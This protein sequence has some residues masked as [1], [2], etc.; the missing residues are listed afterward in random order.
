[1]LLL[2]PHAGYVYSGKVAAS[3]I[4]QIY[5]KRKFEHI[6][7]IGSSHTHLFHGVSIYTEGDYTTPLGNI[8]IDPLASKLLE[9]HS[10]F[11]NRSEIQAHEHALEVILPFLQ[12]WLKN[13]FSI[14]P[15]IIGGES[16]ETPH[17]LADI[18]KP[19]FNENN[20]FIISSDFSHYP[21]YNDALVADNAMAEAIMS[22][23]PERFMQ[24]KK[25]L[26]SRHIP[27]LATT[28][29]G[30]TAILTLLYLT[31]GNP[32]YRIARICYQNS[33]DS[34]YGQKNK[35][36]GYLAIAVYYNTSE[37]NPT[38]SY[39]KNEII[40]EPNDKQNLLTIAQNTLE[41]YVKEHTKYQ[42]PHSLIT[43][44]LQQKAG[45]FVTLRKDSKLRGCI[46]TFQPRYSLYLTIRNLTI[47]SAAYD[48]RFDPVEE[49]EL[50]LIDI[51]ISV[52]T[53]LKK[54][55][56]IDEIEIGKDGIF[57]K[58]GIFSGTF[59][60]QVATQ[61]HW[62]KEEFLGHC[63]R[64]KAGIG[65]NGWKDAEIFTFRTIVIE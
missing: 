28:A 50:P 47:S 15:I 34:P 29:C 56:N 51:E 62:T 18:L 54:I 61:M 25:E 45:A 38:I 24:T 32:Q 63:A 41:Q 19:Y 4:A 39:E 3:A 64:D 1:M 60:P 10:I 6:F 65:W 7:L 30:W 14:V 13:P 8:P 5:P 26:E 27:Q 11:N 2:S 22:G 12:Y 48:H 59:L 49:N 52:L 46:G 55:H 33:G 31:N 23:L 58:K 57:L 17:K 37:V 16:Q 9:E 53:P 21:V 43:P 36:V 40:L 42:I 44:N 35:V 20:L